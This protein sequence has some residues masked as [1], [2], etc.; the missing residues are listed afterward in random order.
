MRCRWQMK[1]GGEGAAV[2]IV[3]NYVVP[4]DFGHRKRTA[5]SSRT[6]ATKERL[7]HITLVAFSLSVFSCSGLVVIAR[8]RFAHQPATEAETISE[9]LSL[10]NAVHFV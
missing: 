1:R 9:G 3:N 10:D 7:P 8:Q 4:D 5:L 2:K 6:E